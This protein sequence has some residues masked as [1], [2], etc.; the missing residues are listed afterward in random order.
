M[1]TNQMHVKLDDL[2]TA[3]AR[4]HKGREMEDIPDRARTRFQAIAEILWR[5][6]AYPAA[7]PEIRKTWTGEAK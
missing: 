5:M 4:A 1:E 6:A 7:P 2:Q 3:F